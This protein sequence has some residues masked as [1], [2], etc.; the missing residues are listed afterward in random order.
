[1]TNPLPPDAHALV[2]LGEV[3]GDLKGLLRSQQELIEHLNRVETQHSD[4]IAALTARISVLEG[5]RLK[6]GYFAVGAA[7]FAST[8]GVSLSPLLMGLIKFLTGVAL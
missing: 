8:F 2:I 4:R 3:R 5:Y 7:F 1:M 6:I